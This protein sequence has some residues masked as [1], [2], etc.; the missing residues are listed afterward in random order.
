M[1]AILCLL[2]E[3]PSTAWLHGTR[4]RALRLG[5]SQP[6]PSL[7]LEQDEVHVG[8]VPAP[9]GATTIFARS[10]ETE[11]DATLLLFLL[12][13]R[14]LQGQASVLLH[15]EPQRRPQSALRGHAGAHAREEPRQQ[16]P[17]QNVVTHVQLDEAARR[18]NAAGRVLQEPAERHGLAQLVVEELQPPGLL[19]PPQEELHQLLR[20]YVRE[21]VVAHV[22]GIQ[23]AGA[24]VVQ[25]PGPLG[26]QPPP[27]AVVTAQDARQVQLPAGWPHCERAWE[28]QDVLPPRGGR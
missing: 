24:K 2:K 9:L 5:G 13:D 28:Q 3:S 26:C 23:S 20:A 10:F 27:Q 15:A 12:Q 7:V 14:L 4:E 17:L 19:A 1:A 25:L 21:A 8:P 6:T 11:L 16:L 18:A 22:Y